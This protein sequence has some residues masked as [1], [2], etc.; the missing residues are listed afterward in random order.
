M[1]SEDARNAYVDPALA[2]QG[3]AANEGMRGRVAEQFA[4]IEAIARCVLD[5]HL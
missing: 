3:Y 5:V 2:L 4:R 1:S